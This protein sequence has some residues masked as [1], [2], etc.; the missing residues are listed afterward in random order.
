[1]GMTTRMDRR[2][3]I[4]DYANACPAFFL[5]S[6]KPLTADIGSSAPHLT[7]H[8]RYFCIAFPGPLPGVIA[9][10]WRL[11]RAR[12]GQSK[13]SARDG[14]PIHL[15]TWNLSREDPCQC[16]YRLFSWPPF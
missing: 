3:G 11:P 6:F 16:G 1:K 7:F 8:Q 12:I 13:G 15:H 2:I 10:D 4:A 5:S 9:R 14:L